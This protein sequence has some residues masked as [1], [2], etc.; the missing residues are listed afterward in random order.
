MKL[1]KSCFSLLIF[2]LL[3]TINISAQKSN[4][5]N[6]FVYLGNQKINNQWNWHNELQYRNFNFLGDLNQLLLRTGIGYN[7]TENNNN[8][9]LGYGFINSQKYISDSNEK[10]GTNE[11]RIYQQFIT[12][13]SFDKVF[14]QHRYR[15][16]ERFLPNDFQMRFRYFIGINIPINK[17]K[18]EKNAF[19][20]SGYNE[21]FI[22]A[23]QH[24]FDRNR[25]YGAIGYVFNKNI[26][27]E[28]GYMAQTVSTGNR[29]QFQIVVFNNIPFTN[30]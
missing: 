6:W 14:L 9:L 7:L 17:P 29:N 10:V 26:K 11:H 21:I 2:F 19:Y 22:N 30:N 13:Q 3:L 24:I 15:I 16:E 20:L 25:L 18:I 4:V 28:G 23:Q 12:K 27:M 1:K 8:I 5:G